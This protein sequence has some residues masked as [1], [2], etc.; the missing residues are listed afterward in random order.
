MELDKEKKEGIQK[1]FDRLAKG[2]AV[3]KG[4]SAAEGAPS[5]G[6]WE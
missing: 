6:R 1:R 3:R 2:D 4:F 5:F